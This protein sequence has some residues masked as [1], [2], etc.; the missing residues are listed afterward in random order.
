MKGIKNLD[1][2]M[3]QFNMEGLIYFFRE[4]F[5]EVKFLK[6]SDSHVFIKAAGW[7]K[8]LKSAS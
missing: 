1:T 5:D 2:K 7:K 6:Y 4:R 8:G 3:R